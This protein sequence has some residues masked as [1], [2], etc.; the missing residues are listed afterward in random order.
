MLNAQAFAICQ[1]LATYG[2]VEGECLVYHFID[3]HGR[4]FAVYEAAGV[5]VEAVMRTS[6]F[7]AI[8]EQCEA[9]GSECRLTEFYF[10]RNFTG[11]G[12]VFTIF[13]G[14]DFI[15]DE[16]ELEKE[17]AEDPED[18]LEELGVL[19]KGFQLL[20]REKKSRPTPPQYAI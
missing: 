12:T 18:N 14:G 3:R 13:R 5:T 8:Q 1:H 6:G 7:R 16:E 17:L 11:A 15:P 10:I 9:L 2:H 4:P 20:V 19:W